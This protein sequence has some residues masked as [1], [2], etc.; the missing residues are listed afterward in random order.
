MYFGSSST[1]VKGSRNGRTFADH[2]TA[3]RHEQHMR[4][5]R[6]NTE[7][8]VAKRYARTSARE[9]RAT[10][11]SAGR[12]S[13]PPQPP[14]RRCSVPPLEV[15][16]LTHRIQAATCQHFARHFGPSAHVN[17]LT[18]LRPVLLRH[19]WRHRYGVGKRSAPGGACAAVLTAE[20]TR[21]P[22]L[23]LAPLGGS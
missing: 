9:A 14:K 21:A 4:R 13:S 23:R 20:N 12:T 10:H 18:R 11:S 8:Q 3:L 17:A 6:R 15:W 22:S 19:M 16:C 1:S 7:A 2:R 5:G